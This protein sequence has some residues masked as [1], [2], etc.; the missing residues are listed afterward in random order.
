[1]IEVFRQIKEVIFSLD[2]S[3]YLKNKFRSIV[4][5]SSYSLNISEDEGKKFYSF[6]G[7]YK[8]ISE[9]VFNMVIVSC[10]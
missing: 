7:K 2:N 5:S 3:I 4:D 8:S 6:I 9:L 10:N 1:M